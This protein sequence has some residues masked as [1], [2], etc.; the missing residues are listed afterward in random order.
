MK[1]G[2]RTVRAT[3]AAV[4]HPNNPNPSVTAEANGPRTRPSAVLNA[5]TEDVSG[6]HQRVDLREFEDRLEAEI[7]PEADERE[8]QHPAVLRGAED[9]RSDKEDQE[10]DCPQLI[11]E[12]E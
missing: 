3:H 4:A 12:G 7:E 5:S 10:G 11:E 1:R 2:G 8:Q 6:K 9:K